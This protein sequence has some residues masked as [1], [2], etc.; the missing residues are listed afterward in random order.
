MLI[1]DPSTVYGPLVGE[2]VAGFVPTAR[3]PTDGPDSVYVPTTSAHWAQLGIAV[4]TACWGCQDTSGSLVPSIGSIQL[5]ANASPTYAQTVTDWTR[6]FVAFADNTASQRFSTTDAGLDLAAGESY[7]AL[8]Y[9]A[10]ENAAGTRRVMGWGG[11]TGLAVRVSSAGA[12]LSVHNAVVA[13][14]SANHEDSLVYPIIVYRNA[15][16]NASG[17]ISPLETIAGT[18]D[19]SAFA[20]GLKGIGSHTAST[21]PTMKTCLIAVWK[22]ATAETITA[23]T[24]T[25]LGW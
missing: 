17:T 18:H 13:S 16:T 11:D 10:I 23:T 19:E 3:V 2:M 7:A 12:L 4:P 6:T 21:T 20:G 25:T 14:G 1:L 9:V 15:T 24:L 22:G 5:A 8:I